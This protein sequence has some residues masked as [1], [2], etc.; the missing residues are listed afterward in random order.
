ME[1]LNSGDSGSNLPAI[2]ETQFSS[3]VGKIPWRRE[4]LPTPVFFAWRI[5]WT[6]EPGRLQCMR[7]AKSQTPPSN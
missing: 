5:P 3:W 1:K 4:W 2:Q 7:V 6:E